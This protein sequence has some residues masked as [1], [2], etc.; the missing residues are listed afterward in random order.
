MSDATVPTIFVGIDISSKAWD[1]HRLDAN[2]S[3]RSA[4]DAAALEALVKRLQPLGKQVL[5]VM[6]ATGGLEQRVAAAL[7]DAGLTV[8]IVNPRQVRD[9]AKGHGLLAKTDRIDARVLAMF[10]QK[11][12]PRPSARTTE[13]EAELEALVV[14][15]RQLVEFRAV[16]SVRFQ[17]ITSKTTQR[18]I[19]KLVQ[20]LKKQIRDI[21]AA[22][23]KLIETN[24]EWRQKAKLVTSTPGIG[25]TTAATLVAELPE[26]GQL[27]R[28]KISALVGVAPFNDDSGERC[29]KRA[30]RGG[31]ASVRSCL[32]MATLT[33]VR[34]N[35]SIAAFY[36]RLVQSGKP[37]KV[38]LVACMRKLLGILNVLVQTKTLWNPSP[39]ARVV[40]AAS[41]DGERGA[42]AR[43]G[44]H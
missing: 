37:T 31:R 27:N 35:P 26:L 20:A 25:P 9:F 2:Q 38:A 22:I 7:M 13:Q 14:R 29:G 40:K 8:A 33:S 30:I 1:I 43:G 41:S 5:I 11:V 4:T 36:K 16:E 44:D 10:A 15:R 23:A 42:G 32:Y 21:E 39:Q 18:S 19:A 3:W 17:Q 34:F 12:G 28:Q 24:D 6:E